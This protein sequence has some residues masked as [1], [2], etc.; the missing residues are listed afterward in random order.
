[1]EPPGTNTH[2][3]DIYM[4]TPQGQPWNTAWKV[5]SLVFEEE[6]DVTV[7]IKVVTQKG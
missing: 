2:T 3:Q 7:D 4:F 1:M 6:E 5:S